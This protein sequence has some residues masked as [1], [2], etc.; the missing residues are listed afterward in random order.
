MLMTG[1]RA[2]S[3]PGSRP[4][5][6]FERR[7]TPPVRSFRKALFSIF[8]AGTD[9]FSGFSRKCFLIHKSWAQKS[10]QQP[11]TSAG[12]PSR[13]RDTHRAPLG[14]FRNLSLP[15]R[16]DLIWCGSLITHIDEWAAV[17]LLDF[18][19]RH[20]ADRGVCVFTTLGQKFAGGMMTEEGEEERFVGARGGEVTPRL[21]REGLW[22]YR[23]LVGRCQ[24]IGQQRRIAN[25]AVVDDRNG[26]KRRM[27]GTRLLSGERLARASRRV[28][29]QTRPG[30][31]APGILCISGPSWRAH[32]V[33]AFR[34]F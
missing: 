29:V 21:S 1:R 13:F 17:D 30:R 22:V 32:R 12:G 7:S 11:L 4:A 19:C 20:L 16:F 31:A 34:H 3:P 26:T 10:R 28:R 18:F 6:R 2:I 23:L 15:H 24:F 9:E 14:S 25:V 33:R 27:L 8:R 5:A